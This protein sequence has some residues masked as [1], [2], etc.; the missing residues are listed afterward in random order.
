M[1]RLTSGSGQRRA[2]AAL[3]VVPV[4][5]A[6]YVNGGQARELLDRRRAGP[7]G[8]GEPMQQRQASLEPH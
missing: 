4:A 2:V 3:A 6:L 7:R 5:A 8:R 1:A